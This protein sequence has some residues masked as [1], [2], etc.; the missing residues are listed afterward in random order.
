MGVHPADLLTNQAVLDQKVYG[1]TSRALPVQAGIAPTSPETK[2]AALPTT[3]QIPA[4]AKLEGWVG[5]NVRCPTRN[6]ARARPGARAVTL[7]FSIMAVINFFK[8]RN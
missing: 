5:W 6:L 3:R 2:L 8:N 7:L 4:T 1:H